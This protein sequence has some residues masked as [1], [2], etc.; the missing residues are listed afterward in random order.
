[1]FYTDV[2]QGKNKQTN[3]DKYMHDHN[4]RFNKPIIIK[5]LEY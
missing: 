1:M 2:V 3:I 5:I 4:Y